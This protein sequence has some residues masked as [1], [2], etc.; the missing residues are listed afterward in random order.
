MKIQETHTNVP[1]MMMK[2]NGKEVAYDL[3]TYVAQYQAKGTL[4]SQ[5]IYCTSS[6]KRITCFGDNLHSKVT[7]H[8]G[9]ENLLMSFVCKDAKGPSIKAP[10]IGKVKKA[11][12]VIASL[13]IEQL[14]AAL[15][16]RKTAAT[17][18]E[19][20]SNDGALVESEVTDTDKELVAAGGHATEEQIADLIADRPKKSGRLNR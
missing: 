11:D 14:E 13:S 12:A 10:V 8:G 20:E 3:D 15:A 6:G 9:I 7:K 2:A 16:A 18:T 1:A 17:A 19:E 4:P 5:H